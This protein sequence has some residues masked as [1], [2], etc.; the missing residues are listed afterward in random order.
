M[1]PNEVRGEF[2]IEL[3]GAKHLMRPSWEAILAF[4]TAL[5]KCVIELAQSASMGRLKT[6]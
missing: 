3:D 5:D 6:R 2:A 1:P 4:E